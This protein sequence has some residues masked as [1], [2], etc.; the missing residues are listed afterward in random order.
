MRVNHARQRYL[1]IQKTVSTERGARMEVRRGLHRIG[2]I[3]GFCLMVA[4]NSASA[5]GRFE[6]QVLEVRTVDGSG[7]QS[8]ATDD[9]SKN[10]LLG[11]RFVVNPKTGVIMGKWIS[12]EHLENKVLADGVTRKNSVRIIS[13]SKITKEDGANLTTYLEIY[14]FLPGQRKSFHMHGANRELMSGICQ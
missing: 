3:L 1:R 9:F 8:V 6:C 4:N 12:T 11:A 7:R 5:I 10:F 2:L 14:S 13:H